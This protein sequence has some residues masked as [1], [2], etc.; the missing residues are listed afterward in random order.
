MKEGLDKCEKKSVSL[1]RLVGLVGMLVRV[2][3]VGVLKYGDKWFRLV[4]DMLG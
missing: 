1:V 3:L 4:F 2:M